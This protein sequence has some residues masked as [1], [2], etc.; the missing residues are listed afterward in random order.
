MG[1]TLNDIWPIVPATALLVFLLQSKL[2][3]AYFALFVAV[4][5][6]VVGILMSQGISG[7]RQSENVVRLGL[8]SMAYGLSYAAMA[9]MLWVIAGHR[10]TEKH[11]WY[12][13][14]LFHLGLSFLM[15]QQLY[16][17]AIAMPR[18]YATF[19]QMMEQLNWLARSGT[20]L[21]C[22]GA[23]LAMGAAGIAISRRNR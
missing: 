1:T 4:T 9:G 20:L 13:F 8:F 15:T 6:M 19:A 2:R 7:V 17:S 21:A 22:I 14:L 5:L 3:W 23:L 10:L 16:A 18:R 12:I 11:S